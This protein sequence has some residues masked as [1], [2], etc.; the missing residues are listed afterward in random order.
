MGADERAQR[1]QR[2]VDGQG[3]Q[4]GGHG[5]VG[6]EVTNASLAARYDTDAFGPSCSDGRFSAGPLTS[7]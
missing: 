1:R 4:R 6:G 3:G 5:A 7:G 2:G